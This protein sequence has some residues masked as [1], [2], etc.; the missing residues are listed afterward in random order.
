MDLKLLK[1]IKKPTAYKCGDVMLAIGTLLHPTPKENRETPTITIREVKF[2]SDTDHQ[3]SLQKAIIQ[4]KKLVGYLTNLG[5]KV[6]V[7][8]IPIGTGGTIFSIHTTHALRNLGLPST[9]IHKTRRK[10]HS[11]AITHLHSIVVQGRIMEKEFL[12][13]QPH[14]SHHK[15]K[16]CPSS[17]QGSK[18]RQ[19]TPHG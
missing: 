7:C 14:S 5:Y 8:S 12:P 1:Q 4:H 10:L 3:P 15:R 11:L 16:A 19:R 9:I 2:S 6:H 18:K 17:Q 13:Q